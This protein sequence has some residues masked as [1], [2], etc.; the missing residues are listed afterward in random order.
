MHQ[1]V[2][3]DQPP[4]SLPTIPTNFSEAWGVAS[5]FGKSIKSLVPVEYEPLGGAGEVRYA[6]DLSIDPKV[7]IQRK[8]DL[9]TERECH[10]PI[11]ACAEEHDENV[12]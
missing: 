6:D 4:P 1:I 7:I 10:C 12:P 9:I 5:S 3:S 11:N 2:V 8:H